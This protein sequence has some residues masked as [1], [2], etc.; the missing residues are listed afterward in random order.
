MSQL[1]FD[2]PIFCFPH[3][4]WLWA[5]QSRGT[6]LDRE[7]VLVEQIRDGN[8]GCF[9]D[10][11]RAE[12]PRAIRLAHRLVGNR[13]DAEEI[14][15]EAFLRFISGIK[16]FRGECSIGTWIYRT[17]TRLAIDHLRRERLRQQ[18]FFFRKSEDEPEP[19]E[20]VADSRPD[21]GECVI[22]AETGQRLARAME[23]LPSRQRA[24]LVLRHQEGLPL[25]EIA[26]L[27][28]LEEGTVKAHLHR[29]V[30]RLRREL[31]E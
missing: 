28:G 9:E 3:L 30:T 14:A 24:V 21:P 29:A 2:L 10:L 13:A 12:A 31:G 11:V 7:S 23:K 25:K 26:C 15:Q 17:V 6:E 27:L 22:G 18:L 4:S 5:S 16:T 1:T 20:Y 8:P 19:M